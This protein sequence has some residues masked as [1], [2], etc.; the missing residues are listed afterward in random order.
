MKKP[1]SKTDPAI[2][3]LLMMLDEAFDKEAWHGPNLRGA[4]RRLS[5][6]QAAW[7]PAPERKNIWELAVH[8]AYWKYTV[9]RLL[10]GQ[11]RGSF[12]LEGSNWFVRPHVVRTLRVPSEGNGTRS[13]PITEVAWR[14][15]VK[16][17]DQMHADL[18]AA[19]AALAPDRLDAKPPGSKHTYRRLIQGAALHDVYHAGQ[20]QTLKRLM[21]GDA[22][23]NAYS[24]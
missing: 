2:A 17:L 4:L 13:V 16:L 23:S 8:A 24:G 3:A 12:P 11:K 19:V 18:R 7:R 1:R 15:D 9:L 14:N 5:A 22:E 21:R 6:E 20:I 10:T